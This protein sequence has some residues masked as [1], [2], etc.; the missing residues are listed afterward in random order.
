MGIIYWISWVES[1]EIILGMCPQIGIIR[2]DDLL[3]N[4]KTVVFSRETFCNP[5]Q[6]KQKGQLICLKHD[7]G[8][9][10]WLVAKPGN[11]MR[12]CILGSTF[13]HSTCSY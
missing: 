6:N 8:D 9:Q 12:F 4:V 7:K 1:Q 3:G 11:M 10:L 13:I 2:G 5:S